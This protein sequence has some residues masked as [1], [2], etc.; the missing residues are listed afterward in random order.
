MSEF[1]KDKIK[2]RK[3]RKITAKYLNNAAAYYLG[4]YASSAA[5]LKR[6][7]MRKAAKSCKYHKTSLKDAEKLIDELIIK[8]NELGY[9]DDPKYAYNLARQLRNKGKS[10]K[11]IIAKMYE[12][13]VDSNIALEAIEKVDIE[14]K[15]DGSEKKA[16]WLLAKRRGL[17][18][19]RKSDIRQKYREKDMGAFARAGFSYEIALEI[20]NLE[21]NIQT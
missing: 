12:K 11:Q 13:L 5:N 18:P 14:L 21:E 2:R 19:F 17:G 7:L 3:P 10:K 9:L 16:A 8:Y 15:I 4:R 6:I 20:L 1:F